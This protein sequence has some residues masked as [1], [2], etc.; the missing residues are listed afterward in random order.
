MNTGQKRKI[1]KPLF[2]HGKH[3]IFLVFRV[4]MSFA[5]HS[6]T[7]FGLQESCPTFNGYSSSQH[8]PSAASAARPAPL[9]S[10]LRPLLPRMHREGP[11]LLSAFPTFLGTTSIQAQKQTLETSLVAD[12]VP[13]LLQQH[14]QTRPPLK[15]LTP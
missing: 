11:L 13:G 14:L 4:D 1:V 3:H 2:F 5:H 7:I 12:N 10:S 9:C 15:K 8:K 6:L